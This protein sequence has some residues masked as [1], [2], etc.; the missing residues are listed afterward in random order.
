[1]TTN[2]AW[3]SALSLNAV[4]VSRIGP[5]HHGG[6]EETPEHDEGTPAAQLGIHGGPSAMPSARKAARNCGGYFFSSTVTVQESKL[7]D[8]TSRKY[9]PAPLW[10][11]VSPVSSFWS[12]L[13]GMPPSFVRSVPSFSK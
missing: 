8:F 12:S 9:L 7:A 3:L 6:P 11:A 5:H 13:T 1:M 10:I 4:Q 2:Y